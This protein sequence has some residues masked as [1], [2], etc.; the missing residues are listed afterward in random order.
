MDLLVKGIRIISLG[1]G[2]VVTCCRL[3]HRASN[4]L[5]KSHQASYDAIF[6]GTFIGLSEDT[7]N[8]IIESKPESL[9]LSVT[10]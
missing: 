5:P 6:L 1:W 2:G 3:A 9:I 4:T 7:G 8:A 10:A